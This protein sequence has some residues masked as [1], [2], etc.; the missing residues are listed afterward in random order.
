MNRRQFCLASAISAT[1]LSSGCVTAAVWGGVGED[2][3]TVTY[4]DKINAFYIREK[5]DQFVILSDQYHY[6]FNTE[7]VIDLLQSSLREHYLVD[8]Q[9][10]Y[11]PDPQGQL[12]LPIQGVLAFALVKSQLNAK[13][14][15]QAQQ[16]GF[17]EA[18]AQQQDKLWQLA[19]QRGMKMSKTDVVLVRQVEIFGK[20]FLPQKG[21]DYGNSQQFYRSYTVDVKQTKKSFQV[22]KTLGAVLITPI[23]V[24]ADGVLFLLGVPLYLIGGAVLLFAYS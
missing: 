3:V 8:I 23:T 19:Q 10:M 13:Q 11:M 20:R 17:Q 16:L 24:A 4:Q 9:N 18:P 15:T 6:I 5:R 14:L 1:V 7:V 22:A 21:I 12:A 2:T